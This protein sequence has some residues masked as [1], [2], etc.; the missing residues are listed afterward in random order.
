[1]ATE[2]PQRPTGG[3]TIL[4]LLVLLVIVAILAFW[5]WSRNSPS[6]PNPTATAIPKTVPNAAPPPSK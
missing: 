2:P 4:L 5:A 1:M 3:S 6:T